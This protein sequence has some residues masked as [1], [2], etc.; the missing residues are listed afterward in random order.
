M[1]GGGGCA[2]E[3]GLRPAPTSERMRRRADLLGGL[4]GEGYVVRHGLPK[5]PDRLTTNVW[6]REFRVA[7]GGGRSEAGRY[8]SEDAGVGGRDAAAGLTPPVPANGRDGGG[9]SVIWDTAGFTP[10]FQ[11]N[12]PLKA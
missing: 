11:T 10:P 3:A 2:E 6:W 4:V 7:S 5:T 1:T 9:R 12:P 8:V